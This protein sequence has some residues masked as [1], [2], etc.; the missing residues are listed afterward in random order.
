MTLKNI[1]I[2]SFIST[3]AV[4]KRTLNLKKYEI[5]CKTNWSYFNFNI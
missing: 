2:R 3:S 5:I 4:K 1:E